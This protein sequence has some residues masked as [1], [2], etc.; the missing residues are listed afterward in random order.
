M[1]PHPTSA[2]PH[3]SS[4]CKMNQFPTT[5][6]PH[7]TPC[8]KIKNTWKPIGTLKRN[9]IELRNEG[10]GPNMTYIMYH[11]SGKHSWSAQ[12]QCVASN[13]TLPVEAEGKALELLPHVGCQVPLKW[14]P[15]FNLSDLSE[16]QQKTSTQKNKFYKRPILNCSISCC[17]VPGWSQMHLV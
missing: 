4:P 15:S 2:T 10:P 17:S 8:C 9:K 5:M 11:F 16:P 6:R 12:V 7:Q 13:K 14:H 3:T 1:D